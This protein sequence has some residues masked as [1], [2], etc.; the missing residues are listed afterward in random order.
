MEEVKDASK[1]QKEETKDFF[2]DLLE[3][4]VIAVAI[5]LFVGITLVVPNKVEGESMEKTFQNGDLLLTNKVSEWLGNTEIGKNLGLDYERGDVIIFTTSS[6]V[7]LIKRVIAVGGDV[8][9]IHDGDVYVNGSKLEESYLGKTTRTYCYTG[10]I[11]YIEDDQVKRIPEGY[12]FVLGDNRENSKDS[13]FTEIGVV[14]RSNIKGK[15]FFRYWPLN[16][17]STIGT[18]VY[19]EVTDNSSD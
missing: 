4:F 9:R 17:I 18:G 15:V 8:V 14:P 2:T 3:S 5:S 7:E 19:D 6:G 13:R 12:Y 16:N 1:N 11:A 10:S